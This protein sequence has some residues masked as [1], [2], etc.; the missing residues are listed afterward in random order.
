MPRRQ[1]LTS[2]FQIG[3]MSTKLKILHAGAA[4]LERGDFRAHLF[5]PPKGSELFL[6]GDHLIV[7]G[8]FTGIHI[9]S[10]VIHS[11]ESDEDYARETTTTDSVV[12]SLAYS[13]MIVAYHKHSLIVRAYDIS[14]RRTRTTTQ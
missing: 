8:G 13:N 12:G 10:P 9:W 5:E 14:F 11:G 1:I 4:V 3:D 6:K 7:A 2:N